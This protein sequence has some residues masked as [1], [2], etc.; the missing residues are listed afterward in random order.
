MK[1]TSINLKTLLLNANKVLAEKKYLDK[2]I[3]KFNY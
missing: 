2:W 3:K 1:N